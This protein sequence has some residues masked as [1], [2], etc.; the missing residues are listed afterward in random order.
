MGDR[1]WPTVVLECG[2]AESYDDLRQ[3]ATLLLEGSEGGIGK[4]IIVQL[5]A[6]G[7]SGTVEKGFLE[8]LEHN[9]EL[10]RAKRRG[11]RF[12]RLPLAVPL[13]I[14]TFVQNIF[15]PPQSRRRQAIRFTAGE[16]LSDRFEDEKTSDILTPDH[17]LPPFGLD[18]LRQL[19]DR[20]VKRQ[21]AQASGNFHEGQERGS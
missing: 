13:S 10:R 7:Y 2:Y 9:N 8:V 12:V 19:V 14:L 1:I 17:I 20:G 15:P 18:S 6:I 16:V 21:A 11:G 3:D 5:D 4:V